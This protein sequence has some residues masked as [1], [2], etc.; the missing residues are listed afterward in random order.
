MTPCSWHVH[1]TL[2]FPQGFW[3]RPWKW[4]KRESKCHPSFPPWSKGE[5]SRLMVSWTVLGT[6]EPFILLLCHLH[7]MASNSGVDTCLWSHLSRNL[8][9]VG[10]SRRRGGQGMCLRGQPQTVS[11]FPPTSPRSEPSLLASPAMKYGPWLCGYVSRKWIPGLVG[12]EQ[13]SLLLTR[14]TGLP[15]V[16]CRSLERGR[17]FR[18]RRILHSE[19]H[20]K[21]TE[22]GKKASTLDMQKRQ[23]WAITSESYSPKNTTILHQKIAEYAYVFH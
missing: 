21:E 22:T 17:I 13:K 3:L 12:D 14:V 1:T 6:Q 16:R 11:A 4:V 9:S 15:K 10:G 18:S 19:S 8:Q 23:P 7:A 5:Q 20:L 2:K